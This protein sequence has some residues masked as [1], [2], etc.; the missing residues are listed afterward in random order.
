MRDR[1]G[2]LVWLLALVILAAPAVAHG[3]QANN[4]YDVPESDPNLPIPWGPARYTDGGLYLA[5]EFL[6]FQEHNPLASQTVA[7]R[8]FR[9]A[10]GVI[11][12]VPGT[13]VGSGVM[14]LNTDQVSG[15][16]T[17][18]PGFTSTIGWRCEDGMTIQGNWWHVATARYSA[19]AS[20]VP[21]DFAVG[22]NSA[23][24]FLFSPVFN[25][26]DN[27]A[28]SDPRLRTVGG[29]LA[30][31]T[32][33]GIW[34]GASLMTEQFTQRFD[35]FDIGS[36]I[37]V[38]ETDCWRSYALF[39]GRLVWL[40]E[41]YWWQTVAPNIDGLASPLDV[42]NYTNIISQRLYGIYC[43]GGNEWYLGSNHFGGLS[44]LLDWDVAPLLD[45]AKLRARY[46][47]GD[48]SMAAT[49]N[50]Q[51]YTLVGEADASV[52]LMW[53]PTRAIQVRFGFDFLAFFNTYASPV[54]IDFNYGSIDPRYETGVFRWMNGFRFGFSVVF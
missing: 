16:S 13:F 15:P 30:S 1:T 28:G 54:P 5:A 35:R 20:L 19:T 10:N 53:Y 29:A 2:R 34:N 31:G 37:P 47:L 32:T 18:E 42:A 11:T 49:H 43:G 12:G 45:I 6:Y 51:S 52:G 14:A 24:S 7:V 36:R 26:P 25:F 33:F 4:F 22:P 38:Y 21:R 39:G 9:D 17:Y 44:I 8:G 27:F 3:Q 23:D 46:E 48:R 40:W 50:R 41:R